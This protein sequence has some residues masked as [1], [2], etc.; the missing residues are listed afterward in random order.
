MQHTDLSVKNTKTGL[1]FKCG[2]LE[3]K[4]GQLDYTVKCTG[5]VCG[6]MLELEVHHTQPKY[7]YEGCIRLGEIEV[8]SGECPG[9]AVLVGEEC[10]AP[11]LVL[12]YYKY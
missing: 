5:E 6:D 2:E 4:E 12:R 10:A 8:Y 9:L 7:S 3:V 1:K 11:G